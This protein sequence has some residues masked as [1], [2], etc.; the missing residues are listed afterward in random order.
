M[1]RD[2]LAKMEVYKRYEFTN[3]GVSPFS[4][5]GTP[6][7]MSLV[8]GNEHDEFGLVSVDP[9][10]RIKQVEKR[11]KKL[12][13][14]RPELPK[15]VS[16][17]VETAEIGFIGVG[18]TYGVILEAMD[19]LAESDIY[20]QYHQL[21]TI[22]PMLEET[23]AFTNRCKVVFVLEYNAGAQLANIIISNGGNAKKIKN[24]LRFDGVPMNS[25]DVVKEVLNYLG[26]T[27]V[28]V[29]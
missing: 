9:V 5:P 15:A 14:L 4:P 26:I 20:T 19:I 8:T 22:H 3:D 7:G 13:T 28:N 25:K 27:E 2:T 17:G 1:T 29:A 16:Y 11:A 23:A 12:E 24:I 6:G 18:M 21:R 10:N